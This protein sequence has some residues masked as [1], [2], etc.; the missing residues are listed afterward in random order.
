MGGTPTGMMPLTTHLSPLST[1]L[2]DLQGRRVEQPVRG[3]LYI[4]RQPDGST[5]K[6]IK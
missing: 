6:Y 3:Q 1:Q 4:V 2:F 5:C